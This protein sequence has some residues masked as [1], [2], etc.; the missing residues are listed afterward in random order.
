M[1]FPHP[2]GHDVRAAGG[3]VL[4]DGEA[5]HRTADHAGGHRPQDGG[6]AVIRV[7]DDSAEVHPVQRQRHGGEHQHEGQ[8][9]QGEVPVHVP[10][11]Q[12]NQRQVD[13]QGHVADAHVEQILD[14]GGKAVD[15]R[16]REGVGEHEY[17][18]AQPHDHRQRHDD[19]VTFH[20]LPSVSVHMP[21][22]P[23]RSPGLFSKG[24]Y[25]PLFSVL[26]VFLQI[27]PHFA[28]FISFHANSLLS[29]A[30]PLP[31][32]PSA[33]GSAVLSVT[34]KQFKWKKRLNPRARHSTMKPYPTCFPL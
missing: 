17:L 11:R 14:H 9:L 31:F 3:A 1:L 23:R 18:V 7:V 32:A 33:D 4:P 2:G 6:G 13:E 26:Q 22:P 8:V 21:R 10:P 25:T 5:V 29:A 24:E 27:F 12:K 16:R 34:E 20:C 28:R 30:K 19:A 15:A